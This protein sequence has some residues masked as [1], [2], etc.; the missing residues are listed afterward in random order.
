M[1]R[2]V[3]ESIWAVALAGLALLVTWSYLGCDWPDQGTWTFYAPYSLY[4]VDPWGFA[5]Q[6]FVLLCG[7]RATVLH[8]GSGSMSRQDWV[9]V[10]TRFLG[11]VFLA[12]GAGSLAFFF[13]LSPGWSG[14]MAS[15]VEPS[16]LILVGLG[17]VAFAR[18]IA[19]WR[20]LVPTR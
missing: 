16:L 10:G 18:R 12:R 3:R 2:L 14:A 5:L 4:V 20:D 15:L 13:V 11:V 19:A 8:L 17:L 9:F 1:S 7:V 6:A